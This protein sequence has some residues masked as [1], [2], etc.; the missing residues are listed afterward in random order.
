M[1]KQTRNQL[2]MKKNLENI[3][4]RV[5]KY[6]WQLKR[7]YDTCQPYLPQQAPKCGCYHV[8]KFE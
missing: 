3:W 7:I 8:E 1:K 6:L 4:D 2:E 5:N